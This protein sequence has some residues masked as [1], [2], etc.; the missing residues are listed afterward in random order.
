VNPGNRQ[1]II[2]TLVDLLQQLPYA[3]IRVKAAESLGILAVEEAIPL[4]CQAATEESDLQ[5][6][7]AAVNA[8]VVVSQSSLFEPT[9]N[10]DNPADS[11]KNLRDL[12]EQLAGQREAKTLAEDAEKTRIEQKIRKT[13]QEISLC[14]KEYV[15]ELAQGLKR[16]ELPESIAEIVVGELVDEIEMLQPQVKNDELKG[17]LQQILVELKKAE[18]AAAKLKVTIPIVPG[19]VAYELE[20]DTKGVLQKLFPTLVKAYEGLRGVQQQKK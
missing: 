6:C 16:Q 2:E 13:K 11:E 4:L 19:V 18:P 14:E 15:R 20:G 3:R 1:T 12:Y 8:L 17:L 5:V 9:M 7:L 10:F